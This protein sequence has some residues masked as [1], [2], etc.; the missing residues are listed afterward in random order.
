VRFGRALVLCAVVALAIAACDA[1]PVVPAPQVGG[2]QFVCHGVP[3]RPCRGALGA[4]NST[5]VPVRVI[6][7]CTVPVCTPAEGETE[8][9]FLF[10]DGTSEDVGYGW[11][12]APE[13]AQ[14]QEPPVPDGS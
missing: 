14:P 13:P 9:R 3:Q 1:I 8:V 4:S 6:V 5:K 11:A 2:P 12:M 7:R 10:A